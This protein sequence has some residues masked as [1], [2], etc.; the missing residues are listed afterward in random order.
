VIG[1][2][3]NVKAEATHSSEAIWAYLH[4]EAGAAERNAL[5]VAM[6]R[7]PE[8]RSRLERS[9]QVDRLLRSTL[10]AAGTDG[11]SD[12]AL[13]EQ[14][15]AAWERTNASDSGPASQVPR[16]IPVESKRLLFFRRPAAGVIGLAAAALLLLAVSPAWRVSRG[17]SWEKPVCAPLSLRGSSAPDARLTTDAATAARCQEALAAALVRACSARGVTLPPGLAFSL[18]LQALREGAFSATVQARLRTGQSAGEWSGDYSG[19][20]S[21]LGHA[22]ASAASM[23]ETLVNTSGA[24]GGGKRL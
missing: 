17:V 21:F 11:T 5:D 13:V 1:G 4:G 10:P 18:R 3:T 16:F 9:R 14:A 20:E 12:E 22:D 8:L 6:R 23:V 24:A 2:G 7:D 19:L 15:L